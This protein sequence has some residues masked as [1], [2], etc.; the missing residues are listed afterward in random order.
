MVEVGRRLV[1]VGG[2]RVEI[3]EFDVPEPG[4]GEVLVRVHRSQIS[5]GSERSGFNPD[6]PADRKRHLGYTAVGR[7]QAIG[8]GVADYAVGDSVLAWGP[9]S[10]HWIATRG[11]DFDNTMPLQHVENDLTDEQAAFCRLGDVALHGVRR[12]ELQL[13]ESVAVFGQGVVGQLVMALCRISG[14]HP[15]IAVDLDEARLEMA[16][17]NGATHLVNAGKENAVEAIKAIANGGVLSAFHVARDPRI[18]VDCMQAAALHGKV[19]LVGSPPGTVE[20]GL[21]VDLL[22]RELDIRGTYANQLT[23][24]HKYWPWTIQGDRKAIMR[25]IA[26]GELKVDHLISHVARPEEADDVYK[27]IAAGPSGWMSVFFD[28]E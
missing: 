5:A 27:M 23:E 1:Q 15:V 20:L 22:R 16:R 3:E 28:W 18:I 7:V 14:A 26:S 25:L 4:P 13:D 8:D 21:Q 17:I 9:H 6:V 2:D 11:P 24:P 12:A 19:I 10:S